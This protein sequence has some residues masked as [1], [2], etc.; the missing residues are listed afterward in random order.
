MALAHLHAATPIGAGH[1]F[2]LHCEALLAEV[3]QARNLGYDA[4]PVVL[5]PLSFLWQCVTEAGDFDRLQLLE[6]VLPVYGEL[7]RC[8]ADQGL[9]WVQIDEPILAL[10]LPLAWRSAFERAYHILQYSP[11]KK[12]IG[13]WQ[14]ALAGNIGLATGLPVDGLHVDLVHAADQ[15]PMVLD[16][17][18]TYKVLSVGVIDPRNVWRGG[19][20]QTLGH[21]QDAQQRFG[22]DLWI[23]QSAP[24][25]HCPVQPETLEPAVGLDGW[26]SAI[27]SQTPEAGYCI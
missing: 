15:L 27:D 9:G 5:G 10:D 20:E 23:S 14:G 18:P 11:L 3:G 25:R 26:R 24:V 16:R 1:T 4:K 7:L 8:L 13:A 22:S 21:L 17:L 6:R 12:M 2:E 19:I